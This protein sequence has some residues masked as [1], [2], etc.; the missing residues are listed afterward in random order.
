MVGLI[1]ETLVVLHLVVKLFLDVV[2]HLVA[3]QSASNLIGHVAQECEIVRCEVLIVLLVGHLKDTDRVIA[4]FNGDKKHIADNLVQLLVHGHVVTKLIL[5]RLILRS[6][7]V[8]SLTSIE[9]LTKHIWSLRF[10]RERQRLAEPARNN[11]AEKLV[12]DAVVE[13]DRAAL[14]VKQVAEHLDE[15][16]QVELKRVVE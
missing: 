15:A 16:R 8:T 4:K 10:A 3:D 14:N 6:L 7:K 2:L 1:H 12:L 11:F 5:D 9:D 13:E